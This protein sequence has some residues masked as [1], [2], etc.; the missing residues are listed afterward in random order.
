MYLVH[1]IAAVDAIMSARTF[2]TTHQTRY[3]QQTALYKNVY[4][5][6][7]C[8]N[9]NSIIAEYKQQVE[10]YSDSFA[11]VAAPCRML[12][13]FHRMFRKTPQ[14]EDRMEYRPSCRGQICI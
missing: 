14:G 5:E 13:R 2:V 10:F 12:R 11:S 8:M 9:N 6:Q 4:T 3:V 7:L 1:T